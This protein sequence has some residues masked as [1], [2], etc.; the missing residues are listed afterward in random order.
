MSKWIGWQRFFNA[1]PAGRLVMLVIPDTAPEMKYLRKCKS[2][3]FSQ[4]NPR[5]T[6]L[7]L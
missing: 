5:N 6:L 3:T 7:G 2:Y 1:L 4:P